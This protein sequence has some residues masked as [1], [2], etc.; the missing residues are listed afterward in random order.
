MGPFQ[1]RR[2]PV[3]NPTPRLIVAIL[4]RK[5]PNDKTAIGGLYPQKTFFGSKVVPPH[6]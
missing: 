4:G 6:F 1:I 5:F 3:G 2:S